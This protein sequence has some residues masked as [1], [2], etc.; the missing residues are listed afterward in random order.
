MR[1]GRILF[2][3]GVPLT[4]SAGLIAASSW[5]AHVKTKHA[6]LQID[7][8]NQAAGA[9]SAFRSR[10]LSVVPMTLG[11]SQVNSALPAVPPPPL[12]R[13]AV[14]NVAEGI[15][16]LTQ[17]GCGQCH[18][19]DQQHVVSSFSG[20]SEVLG[21]QQGNFSIATQSSNPC[22]LIDNPCRVGIDVASSDNQGLA[23]NDTGI[24]LL[25]NE[26]THT[27]GAKTIAQNQTGTVTYNFKYAMPNAAPGTART[28]RGV[29]RV[30]SG[31]WNFAPDFTAVVLLGASGPSAL[32]VTASSSNSLTLTWTGATA[33]AYQ[34][35]YKAGATAPTSPNDGIKKPLV[36][37]QNSKEISGLNPSTQY[38]FSVWG[39]SEKPA[40]SDPGTQ[41]YS[42]N[43][44]SAIG[45][46]QALPP[47][48]WPMFRTG[49]MAT[50]RYEHTA[51]L[52]WNGTVLIAG[53]QN[54]TSALQSAELYDPTTGTFRSTGSLTLARSGHTATALP[55]GKVLIV[56]GCASTAGELYDPATGTFSAT[57]GNMSILRS[58]HTATLLT[59]GKV[60]ITGGTASVTAA[61][62]YDPSAG[63]FSS[64]LNTMTARFF[65][66]ATL[67]TSGK[68]LL[69][70]GSATS[71]GTPVA[72]AELY[73]P[74]ANAFGAA[75]SLTTA[76]K[77][78]SATNSGALTIVGGV[79]S[80]NNSLLSTETYNPSAN[81]FAY[82]SNGGPYTTAKHTATVIPSSGLVMI[83]GGRASNGSSL[84]TMYSEFG[85]LVTLSEPR[86]SHTA[87]IL[88]D[89]RV[90]IAGGNNGT[91]A[92]PTPT[93]S[94]DLYDSDMDVKYSR[95]VAGTFY[96]TGSMTHARAHH[97]ATLLPN[98]K[99]LIA[100]GDDG[101]TEVP[102]AELYD[103]VGGTFST[104]GS[105]AR[106]MTDTT[107]TLL[108]NGKVLCTGGQSA[109]VPNYV[110]TAELYDP[111]TGIF[112]ATGSMGIKRFSHTAT[113]LAN[114][115]VLIV[116]G[117]TVS[118]SNIVSVVASAEL[119]DPNSGTFSPTGSMTRARQHHTATLLPNGKVLVAGGDDGSGS[120]LSSSFPELYDPNSGTFSVSNAATYYSNAR[121]GHLAT[122]LPNGK[123]LFA[124]GQYCAAFS[125]S[126]VRSGIL[127]D[128]ATDDYGLTSCCVGQANVPGQNAGR[129]NTTATLLPDGR[130]IIIGGFNEGGWLNTA[131]VYDSSFEWSSPTYDNL[132][133]SGNL[134]TAR[135]A[136]TATL[137]PDGTVLV[138]GG[139][140]SGSVSLSSAEWFRLS[141]RPGTAFNSPVITSASSSL[142]LPA[143]VS[144]TGTGFRSLWETSS[145]NSQNSAADL[146]LLRLQRVDNDQISFLKP[147][148]RNETGFT[149]TIQT[150][151]ADGYYR[152]TIIA[153]GVPSGQKLIVLRTVSLL[154]PGS[155]SATATSTTSISVVWGAVTGAANYE[156]FRT[157]DNVNYTSRGTVSATN[158]SD[159]AQSGKSYL[160]KVRA[161][162]ALGTI[163]PDSSRDLATAV[164]F[165]DDPIMV[166]TTPARALH[167]T[168]LRTAVNAVR[169]LAGLP[170]GSFV[171]TITAGS[172]SI[173]ASHINELRSALDP[174]RSALA[175]SPVS[176]TDP[177]LTSGLSIK[178]A[179]IT[180][181][182]DGI[183]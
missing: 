63:T 147:S 114:G 110:S 79:D 72:T 141:S 66:T 25:N 116:G 37:N 177:S 92:S 44:A 43:Y 31:G 26:I 13:R 73:D 38:S 146:P 88:A 113:L 57:T 118:P 23:L 150:G 126:T 97:T 171:E 130:A 83:T 109:Y 16:G 5:P 165:T 52:L 65:H 179:H 101:G 166:G 80:S 15:T 46:T 106:G 39:A 145:G 29:S 159:S 28:L 90:L 62:L 180:Q 108:T 10:S 117:S 175:L 7:R 1:V 85:T 51:T 152:A 119:Y 170:G 89:G 182:R 64:T 76:R 136:H 157:E 140:G 9:D 104:T 33:A 6:G 3:I 139:I 131:E 115:K 22:G 53:G 42:T 21:G 163:G 30:G 138:V 176:Y 164:S 124:E 20:P 135:F 178:A 67:L 154:A 160:Y 174:A 103:P 41:L 122:L 167:V 93:S 149:S 45:T 107:A 35:T 153:G 58:G 168:E 100:A 50:A 18:I 40:G 137:L 87:T 98:G 125:C 55:N 172:T 47:N 143:A 162:D 183:K 112:T 151:L 99:V 142:Y 75:G 11:P 56:G 77:Y 132:F 17:T 32:N 86:I 127:Y 27:T 24:Q 2:V 36:F 155:F 121:Q 91:E 4:L 158:L 78:H 84:N 129:Y 144:L 96:T 82:S 156:V 59:T 71:S 74:A 94:A 70:G 8:T 133:A 14:P 81:T 123:V 12:L 134:N 169:T 95:S 34:I 128:P 49:S 181:L 54:G 69:V 120:T 60:F 173:K 102:E 19:R 105:M 68:V 161:L 61:D 148:A 111:D 48:T